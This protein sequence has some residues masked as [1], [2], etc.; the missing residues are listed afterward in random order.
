MHAHARTHMVCAV[1]YLDLDTVVLQ[2]IDHLF[3]CPGLCGVLRHSEKLNTGVMVLTPS[4]TLAAELS[5]AAP[6][7]PSYT[8]YAA[9]A[10][11]L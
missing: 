3:A 9:L 11:C 5:A 1:I 8:G 10:W 7:L 6:H 2:S 4:A